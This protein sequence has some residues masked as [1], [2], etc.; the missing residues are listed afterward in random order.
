MLD[1]WVQSAEA[2]FAGSIERESVYKL[3]HE[4]Q[5]ANEQLPVKSVARRLPESP[6]C[7]GNPGAATA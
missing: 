6:F 5:Y 7:H 1:R 3:E 2:V 4:Y